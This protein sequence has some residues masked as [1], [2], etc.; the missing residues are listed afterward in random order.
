VLGSRNPK[1]TQEFRLE[2]LQL[3]LKV[4]A[5]VGCFLWC[6]D[7]VARRPALYGVQNVNVFPAQPHPSLNNLGE[8]LTRSPYK[9]NALRVFVGP[10]GLSH[11]DQSRP[12]VAY[13]EDRIPPAASQ[14][15]ASLAHRHLALEALQGSHRFVRVGKP[16]GFRSPL[17]Q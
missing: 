7:A 9:W 17:C 13:P 12:G 2:N 11:E 16:R 5:A 3:S 8:F 14:L 15:L 1:A 6:G 4:F 10:G